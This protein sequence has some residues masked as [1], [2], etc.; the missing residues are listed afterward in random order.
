VYCVGAWLERAVTCS[1]Y[2]ISNCTTRLD[3]PYTREHSQRVRAVRSSK[4]HFVKE[5]GL[6][7]LSA[8]LLV[9]V[10]WADR[11]MAHYARAFRF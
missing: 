2:A 9:H 6:R 8:M 7:W 11:I 5:N 1:E 4:K 3:V 10:P